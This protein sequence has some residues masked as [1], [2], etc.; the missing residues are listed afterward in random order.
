MVHRLPQSVELPDLGSSNIVV[1]AI[2]LT[3]TRGIVYNRRFLIDLFEAP[4]SAAFPS[5]FGISARCRG[6]GRQ[7][8]GRLT[9]GSGRENEGLEVTV[10]AS[11][12]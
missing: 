3:G 11:P 6:E 8:K 9:G 2:H 10:W 12:F 7:S 4:V 5:P 1:I